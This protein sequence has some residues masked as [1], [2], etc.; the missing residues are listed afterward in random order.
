MSD[1]IVKFIPALDTTDLDEALQLVSKVD[2][3]PAVY[4]YKVGF[5]LG[6][7]HGLPK[8]VAEIRM[9]S[10]RPI[11]YDHQKAGTD[12]PDTGSL[13]AKTLAQA[14]IDEAIIFSHAGPQTQAAWIKA[15]QQ[16]GLKVI[17][18]A[19]MTHPGFLVSEGGFLVDDK[20][21][22]AYKLAALAGVR[23]FV[24]PL[25]KPGIIEA[26]VKRIGKE[27]AWEFY[28]PGLGTQGG[29][30]QG[31]DLLKRHYAIVGRSLLAAPDPYTYLANL[32]ANSGA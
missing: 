6:L 29:S 27:G 16:A 22:D 28:T 5:G 11:I 17:V 30:A 26:I 14:G 25:T 24:A 10:K 15:L 2:A 19:V 12:I 31:Y 1:R 18:G 8:V 23:A 32:L 20:V 7:V 4:G 9:C 13:F 3:H 21:L